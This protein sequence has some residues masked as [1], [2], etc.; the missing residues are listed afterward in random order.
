MR[1]GIDARMY[2]PSQGGLGRYIEQLI[3]HLEKTDARN[4]YAIFL[5]K[6]NW[7]E[8]EP[9]TP[10]FHKILADVPWYGWAEQIKMPLIIKKEKVDLMH[11]PHWNIPFFYHGRFI[12]TIHDLIL[13]HYPSRQASA[14]GP[15]A[16]W[17]K[18]LAYKIIL[19]RAARRAEHIIAVSEY[20]KKD[21][22]QNLK[23]SSEKISVVHLAPCPMTRIKQD[24]SLQKYGLAR[25]YVLYIGVAYPHKNLERLL[26]AWNIFTRKYGDD[27]Q[28]ALAGKKNYFYNRLLNGDLIKQSNNI[29]FIDF[30]P[31][32]NLFFLL[33]NAS[34]YIFP[35]L[36][37]G[38][39]LPPLE[40]M[41]S[42]TPVISSNAS[43]LPEILGDAAYYFNPSDANE[44]AEAINRGLKDKKMRENLLKNAKQTLARYSWDKTAKKTLEI[45]EK[46]GII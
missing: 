34:L 30:V 26:E 4:E 19:R 10:N 45:Y 6:A 3:K 20:T 31:D 46:F 11:F 39:G 32:E 24:N 43:C 25:P 7:N 23:I 42:N 15:A 18:N 13:F 17:F 37:E 35:S 5:R 38:F 29:V 1:I 22:I 21:I 16:Y 14:L 9:S 44:I 40:A 2:G 12:V 27:Y 33:K 8:Y 36:Y 28:L 41:L